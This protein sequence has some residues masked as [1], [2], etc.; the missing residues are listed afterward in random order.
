[1]KT[2]IVKGIEVA[3]LGGQLPVDFIKRVAEYTEECRI[4]KTDFIRFAGDFFMKKISPGQLY[5]ELG[6]L[7]GK[8]K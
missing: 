8:S 2:K 5:E 3:H 6:K 7:Y 4:S 1:M